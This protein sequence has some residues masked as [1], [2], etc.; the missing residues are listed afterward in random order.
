MLRRPLKAMCYRDSDGFLP[1]ASLGEGDKALIDFVKSL[2]TAL[3]SQRRTEFKVEPTRVCRYLRI[4]PGTHL[5]PSS[6]AAHASKRRATLGAEREIVLLPVVTA[7]PA[8][9]L[10]GR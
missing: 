4:D 8:T 1:T 2:F 3:A 9:G 5:Q 6:H 10:Q 7:Y